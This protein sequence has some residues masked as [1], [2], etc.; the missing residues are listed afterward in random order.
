MQDINTLY[1]LFAL[2]TQT[3]HAEYIRDNPIAAFLNITIT[4][5]GFIGDDAGGVHFEFNTIT[6][7]IKQL[8]N[9][10]FQFQ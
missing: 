8:Q 1:T 7:G 10:A 3:T 5:N 4:G 9:T 6:D 2:W